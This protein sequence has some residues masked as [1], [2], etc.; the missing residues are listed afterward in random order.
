MIN[1]TPQKQKLNNNNEHLSIIEYLH[2]NELRFID[3]HNDYIEQFL[4]DTNTC[5]SKNIRLFGYYDS[6]KRVTNNFT[7]FATRVNCCKI[8][9]LCIYD[10]FQ[11]SKRLI[12]YFPNAKILT[13]GS[14]FQ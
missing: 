8:N 11:T 7:R 2:L 9:C 10:Q 14:N 6:L 3:T 1:E 13:Y 5:L 12:N 4:V